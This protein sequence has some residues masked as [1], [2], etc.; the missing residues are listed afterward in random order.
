MELRK[1]AL[2]TA[3]ILGLGLLTNSA[4]AA[5][6][7]GPGPKHN[8]VDLGT[9]GG[10]FSQASGVDAFTNHVSGSSSVVN[11]AAIHAV[12][13]DGHSNAIT[14]LGVLAGGTNSSAAGVTSLGVATGTSDY[15]DA[16]FGLVQ[17]AFFYQNATLK[18][19]GTL[20]GS[21]SYGTGINEKNQVAG[22]AT[23]AN[24]ATTHGFFYDSSGMALRDLGTLIG[25]GGNS[26]AYAVNDFGA[27]GGSSDTGKF[28]GFG[29]P[30]TDAVIWWVGKT[31]QITDLGNLNGGTYAQVN[32]LNN[33]GV[34]TG[35]ST[36]AS[37]QSDAFVYFAGKMYDIGTLGGS[38]AQGLGVNDLGF[39]VGYSNTTGDAGIDAFVWTPFTGMIDLN[40]LL[41]NG[42]PW[43][44][45]Q[46]SG[47][48]D[49]GKIVGYGTINGEYHAFIY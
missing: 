42:S 14:D 48:N 30:I 3:V 4:L 37:G 29:N 10:M 1:S 40:T 47:I 8:P 19:I 34:A 7:F 5:V 36:L 27:V 46:A 25:P 13:W 43:V 16:V 32:A 17:R 20:G 11:E 2:V 28:D 12:V 6:G 35:F 33:F 31:I 45:L 23:T 49:E 41:P 22:Y 38:A 44:L 26:A 15:N 9:L 21:Q 24:D 18:P 39:V